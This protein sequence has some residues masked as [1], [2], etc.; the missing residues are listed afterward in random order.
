MPDPR[1]LRCRP[2]T[3]YGSYLLYLNRARNFNV[4][5]DVFLPGQT[6][7]VHNHLCWCVFVCLGG[8][9]RERLYDVDES[10]AKKPKQID[11]RVCDVGE[12]RTMD[13]SRRLFHQIECGSNEPA[14]SLHLY[15]ANIGELERDMWNAEGGKLVK[16][17]S[18]YSNSSMGLGPYLE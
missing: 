1:F 17:R 10:L 13:S 11:E 6:A 7:V 8:I 4:V 16:F 14:V 9:E 18:G 3:M 5:L 12:V 15:G 2:D